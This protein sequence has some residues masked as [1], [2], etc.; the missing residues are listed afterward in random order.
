MRQLYRKMTRKRLRELMAHTKREVLIRIW[1]V[2]DC[3]GQTYFLF[4]RKR[5]RKKAK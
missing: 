4:M 1:N 5:K 2:P 3:S